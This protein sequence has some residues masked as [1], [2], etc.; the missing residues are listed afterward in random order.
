MKLSVRAPKVNLELRF[1]EAVYDYKD[2]MT[3][4]I[5]LDAQEDILVDE[6]RLEFD[7]CKKVRGKNARHS[8]SLPL[9]T[10][11]I[12]I[13][14]STIL[15]KGQHY[16]LPF[17]IQIPSY[18]KPDPYTEIEVKVKGVAAVTGRPDLTHEARPTINFPYVIECPK[19]HGGCGY[20]TRPLRR[21]VTACPKCGN[22]LEEIW[23]SKI[24]QQASRATGKF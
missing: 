17:Q 24:R 11:T 15:Q 20:T 16:E 10:R 22:N 6:F 1:D 13:G 3:G 21:P 12:P 18:S 14:N 23:D 8:F 4:R 7:A 19:E 2:K 9:E 5:I